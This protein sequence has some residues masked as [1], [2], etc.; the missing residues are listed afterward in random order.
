MGEIA[1]FPLRILLYVQ[2]IVAVT[3][4][5]LASAPWMPDQS[6][7]RRDARLKDQLRVNPPSRSS[8]QIQSPASGRIGC[9]GKEAHHEVTAAAS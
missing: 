4:Y 2:G 5:Q 9:G 7:C 8:N 3:L 6:H 1:D